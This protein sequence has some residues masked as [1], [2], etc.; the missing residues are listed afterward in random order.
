M[1]MICWK[2]AAGIRINRVGDGLDYKRS[3]DVKRS[4]PS[5]GIAEVLVSLPVFSERFGSLRIDLSFA[6]IAVKWKK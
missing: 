4:P 6:A 1:D 3:T 2:F 5:L